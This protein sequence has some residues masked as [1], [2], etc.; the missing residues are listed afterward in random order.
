MSDSLGLVDFAIGL[1]NSIL[2]WP[3]ARDFFFWGGGGEIQIT[4]DCWQSC[5]PNF[6]VGWWGGRGGLAS[7]NSF[8]ANHASY[9][10]PTWQAVKPSF[11]GPCEEPDVSHI[12]LHMNYSA[13]FVGKLTN[14]TNTIITRF[15]GN[16]FS[17]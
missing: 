2:N 11:F 1:V 15:P 3:W 16:P 17:A 7:W 8:W 9:S 14:A 4:E 13:F 10:L 6:G 12:Y 5:S